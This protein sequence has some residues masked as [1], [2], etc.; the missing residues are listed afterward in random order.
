MPVI[1]G[2]KAAVAFLIIQTNPFEVM[3]A[4]VVSRTNTVLDLWL[5][6]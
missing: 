4:S 1:L 2:E 3:S 6:R 5:I